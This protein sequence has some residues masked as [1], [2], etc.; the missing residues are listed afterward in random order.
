MPFYLLE[1]EPI[2]PGLRRIANEQIGIA[3]RDLSDAAIPGHRKV[4]SLRTRC[5]KL[6]GLL[7]LTQPLMGDAFRLEDQR[8]RT[9]A[10]QL[11]GNRDME[12]C[13]RTIASLD[14]QAEQMT[15]LTRPVSVKEMESSR[16]ILTTCLEA[17]EAWPL[18]IH[19]FYDIAPGFARTYR[20]CLDA[21]ENVIREQSDEHFHRLR[22]WGKYHWYQVRILE[23]LNKQELR[24]RRK[25][26]RKLQLALG[27]AHDIVLLQAYLGSDVNPDMPLL[28]R[29]TA[30]KDELYADA[31]KTG[32]RLFAV[33]VSELVADCSRYWA[34]QRR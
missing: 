21:W 8:F 14:G 32:R 11:A 18:D 6:R 22:R 33:S 30:R 25:K 16:Q 2:A 23:R 5:K 3:L 29:A 9:A 24:K 27:D 12:V 20:K 26:L 19:G 31:V 28:Q 13:A 10:K 7:R 4:H 1:N 15:V 17:V 34:D